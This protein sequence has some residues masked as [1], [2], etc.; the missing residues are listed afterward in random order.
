MTNVQPAPRLRKRR[1]PIRLPVTP[2][3]Q[4][5]A[6]RWHLP[7]PTAAMVAQAAGLFVGADR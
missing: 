1:Q 5:V 2:A 6:R 3:V 4:H 7:L